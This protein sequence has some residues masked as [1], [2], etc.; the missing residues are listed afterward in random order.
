[1][2][3]MSIPRQALE[4]R[5]GITRDMFGRIIEP[6][7]DARLISGFLSSA[8]KC[9]GQMSSIGE[10]IVRD[11]ALDLIALALGKLVG[12]R[13]DLSSAGRIIVHKLRSF[14]DASLED[15]SLDRETIAGAVGVSVRRANEL[16]A[17]E[18]TSI[19]QLLLERRLEHC[20]RLLSDPFQ[21]HRPV[22]EIAY[23]CGF[24]DTAHFARAF[25][26][27]YGELPREYRARAERAAAQI[28]DGSRPNWRL[29]P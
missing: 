20:R 15:P 9:F 17:R 29:K 3:L 27:A 22:S 18:G 26:N 5:I 11:H 25:K 16:L 28:G 23:S 7:G 14:V 12:R 24:A 10:A 4:N 2:E 8:P 19:M 6:N 1:M 21:A 13:V